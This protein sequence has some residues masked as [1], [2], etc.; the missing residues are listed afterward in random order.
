MT[1]LPESANLS[2][3]TAVRDFDRARK[4]AAIQQFLARL[5]GESNDLLSYQDVCNQLQATGSIEHG[6]QEIPLTAVMG[7]VGRYQDFTRSFLPKKDSDEERWARVRHAI[8]EMKGMPPIE[9]YQIGEVYFVKD[10]NHRVS[11]AR[12]LGV[13]TISAY[14]TEVET[15]VPLAVDDDPYEVILKQRY[16]E[17]LEQTN[18]DKLCPDAD[19]TMTFV[20]NYQMLLVQIATHHDILQQQNADTTYDEAV[21]SWYETVYRPVVK[22]INAQG[23]LRNFPNRTEADMYVFITEHREIL[24]DS[25]GW[26]VDAEAAVVTIAEQTANRRKGMRRVFQAIV[27]EE[28]E[29]GPL[30]GR[31]RQQQLAMDRSGHLFADMLVALSGKDTDWPILDQVLQLAQLDQDRILGLHVVKKESQVDSPKVQ[32]IREEF[33]R[34]CEE[35]GL[36]GEFAVDVGKVAPTIVRRAALADLVVVG[37]TH[38]PGEQ[39]LARLGHGLHVLIQQCPRPIL[40]VPADAQTDLSRAL[41]AYDGSSKADEALFV[42]TYLA[43]RWKIELTVVTVETEHTP[44]S[45]LDDARAYLEKYGV[46]AN[47]LL[48][49]KPIDDALLTAADEHNIN[50]MIIGGFGFRPVLHLVLGSTVDRLLREFKQPLLICR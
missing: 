1:M 31:W 32:R 27:P 5:R 24:E 37:I 25:L 9:V 17:F 29:D 48:R 41:L 14:V 47:Y 4:Q 2:Y 15:R 45:T 7:S 21:V 19:L 18:L 38:S 6:L 16:V 43:V 20:G 23:L 35:A 40:A 39:P 12:Q 30:P 8:D 42:A 22:M 13:D 36:V 34:R 28:L 46:T 33:N 3:Q 50:L 11:V 26:E 44:T 10:G 49:K